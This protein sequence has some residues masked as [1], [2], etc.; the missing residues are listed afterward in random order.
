MQVESDWLAELTIGM[1]NVTYESKKKEKRS[2]ENCSFTSFFLLELKTMSDS[3]TKLSTELEY[4]IDKTW[5][6]YVTVT[7]F[8]AQSQPRV[9]QVLNEII[10]LLK[11]VDQMKDQF[12]NVDI[13]GQLLK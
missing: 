1:S 7:D 3:L 9:D 13:P 11:D 6:L 4:L 2:I 8:Q 5:N 10:G 12:Q